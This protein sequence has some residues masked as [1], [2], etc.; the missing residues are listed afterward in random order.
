MTTI[1]GN[2]PLSPVAPSESEHSDSSK[3]QARGR[4]HKNLAD[5][6]LEEFQALQRLSGS[7]PAE[8]SAQ[9]SLPL[10]QVHSP[11]ISPE[12]EQ[13]RQLGDAEDRLTP[14]PA[15]IPEQTVKSRK[16]IDSQLAPPVNEQKNIAVSGS[17]AVSEH[18][19]RDE[20][21]SLHRTSTPV[22]LAIRNDDSSEEIVMSPT[23]YPGQEWTPMNYY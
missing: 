19:F 18:P 6:K 7:K 20:S 8:Y 17:S 1:P 15:S 23:A 10:P 5:E 14:E 9:E 2:Q 22:E 4:E 11:A 16:P 13:S 12:P 21:L 3:S